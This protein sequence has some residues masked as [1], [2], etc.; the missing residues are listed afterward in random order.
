MTERAKSTRT[1]RLEAVCW[2]A[3]LAAV[4]PNT[5]AAFTSPEAGWWEPL[6]AGLSTAFVVALVALLASRVGDRRRRK[7]R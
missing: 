7:G 3:F 6:R 5:I 2:L 1:L 4:T